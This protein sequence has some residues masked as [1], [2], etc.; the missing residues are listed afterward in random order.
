[1]PVFRIWYQSPYLSATTGEQ[2]GLYGA[3]NSTEFI[4]PEGWTKAQAV[5][6]FP[7]RY[8]GRVVKAEEVKHV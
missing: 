1:M 2:V 7:S 6:A 8:G 4:C 3:T 5:R